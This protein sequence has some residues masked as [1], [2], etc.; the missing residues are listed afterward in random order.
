MLV[1]PTPVS[2]L[3]EE[4]KER[5][6][7][8]AP[9]LLWTNEASSTGFVTFEGKTMSVQDVRSLISGASTQQLNG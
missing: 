3:S 9:T 5:L 4:Q 2:S 6:I 7:A 1:Q 8:A